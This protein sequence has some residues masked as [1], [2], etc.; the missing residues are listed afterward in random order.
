MHRAL[1]IKHIHMWPEPNQTF[2]LSSRSIWT[3]FFGGLSDGFVRKCERNDRQQEYWGLYG[4]ITIVEIQMDTRK[5]MRI[6]TNAP[7]LYVRYSLQN[8]CFQFRT[9]SGCCWIWYTNNEKNLFMRI[10]PNLYHSL[11]MSNSVWP[12]RALKLIKSARLWATFVCTNTIKK[13][14]KTTV[15]PAN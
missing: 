1:M 11:Y 9:V 13:Q 12:E 15:Q 14:N 3:A 8:K 2:V 6:K 7:H 10:E 4:R 5:R